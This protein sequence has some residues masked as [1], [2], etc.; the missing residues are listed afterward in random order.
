MLCKCLFYNFGKKGIVAF[1]YYLSP[2]LLPRS[3]MVISSPF[4]LFLCCAFVCVCVCIFSTTAWFS[5]APP[6]YL[7]IGSQ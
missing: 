4:C 7:V 5:G 6:N 2:P 1:S 3:L